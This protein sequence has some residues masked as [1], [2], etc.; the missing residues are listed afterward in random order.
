MPAEARGPATGKEEIVL[1]CFNQD[2]KLDEM[3]WG[4]APGCGRT[5]SEKLTNLWMDGSSG[6]D[7]DV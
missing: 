5:P 4:T 7:P 3:D 2:Q 1:S 6:E